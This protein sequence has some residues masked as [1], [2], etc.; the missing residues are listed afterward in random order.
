M[1]DITHYSQVK[2]DAVLTNLI[3]GY[4]AN[5][6]LWPKLLPK[7]S[8]AKDT[9][10]FYVWDDNGI[11][12]TGLETRRADRAHAA[13][14]GFS[15]STDTY[16]MEQ[17]ALKDFLEDSVTK[18]ADSILNLREAA[19]LN[20][21]DLLDLKR[22]IKAKDLVFTSSSYASGHS[23]TLTTNDRW[24]IGTHANSDPVAD[25][26]AA[27]EVGYKNSR[28]AYNTLV[29]G[30][31][32]FNYLKNHD[33]AKEAIKYVSATGDANM[34]NQ[35]LAS[36]LGVDQILIG[37]SVYNT[38]KEGQTPS[39][40]FIWGD[41]A[42]LLYLPS[43]PSIITPAFGYCFEP[44]HTP[45]TVE[46]YREQGKRGEWVEVN[47]K[48]SMEVTFSKAGYFFENAFTTS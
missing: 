28:L 6:L 36:W 14:V 13:E 38:A 5:T 34:T 7:L 10:K 22:E 27:K 9:D 2:T 18:N 35:V 3:I 31:K 20:V 41:H 8:V 29:V 33:K 39:P 25:I 43:R 40:D 45:R 42:A 32:G 1:A 11:N 19:A 47:E 23:T 15:V 30:Y 21:T 44:S 12:V 46:R 24:S 37:V 26:Q 4:G 16:T 48:Y 17:H